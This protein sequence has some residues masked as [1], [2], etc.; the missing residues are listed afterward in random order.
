[1]D[2]NPW[3]GLS[4]LPRSV[5]AIC[6]AGLIN[7]AGTMVLPYIA[8]W[9]IESRG[10]TPGEAGF[11]ASCYGLGTLVAAPLGGRL[12][13]RFGAV[14]VMRVG[15]AVAGSLVLL[16]PLFGPRWALYCVLFVWAAFGEL[17]RPAN[18]VALSTLVPAEDRRVALSAGRLSVNL[19]MAIGPALGGVLIGLSYWLLFIVDGA[20][21]L[22]AAV[23]LW[24][25]VRT[26]TQKQMDRGNSSAVG[27]LDFRLLYF[28]FAFLPL[29]LVFVQHS[30]V[31]LL[32]LVQDL[33][34]TK[35]LY[36]FLMTINTLLIVFTEV[37]LTTALRSWRA[38]R[39]LPLAAVLLGLG[40][41]PLAFHPSMW[42]VIG[43]WVVWTAGEMIALPAGAAYV[44]ELAPEGGMGRYLGAYQTMMSGVFA[45]GPWLGTLA[46]AHWGSFVLW[47]GTFALALLSAVLLAGLSQKRSA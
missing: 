22:A 10:F 2:F 29:G 46:F 39:A 12:A 6:V 5:K 43:G 35:A 18:L 47:I 33:H 28:L 1:M 42:M 36:G 30:T 11:A 37:R 19:G 4:G 15:L 20:T 14:A 45:V 9:L 8:V 21:S 40:F 26:D 17:F 13:D 32:F 31:L 16:V 38:S 27:P 25:V 3:R 44:A 7:R 24:L 41:L 23:W 34:K